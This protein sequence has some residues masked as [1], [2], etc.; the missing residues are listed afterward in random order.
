M[1]TEYWL[2]AS[3]DKATTFDDCGTYIVYGVGNSPGEALQCSVDTGGLLALESETVLYVERCTRELYRFIHKNG[4]HNVK[5]YIE[6]E[7]GF[8]DVKWKL[9]KG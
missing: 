6:L 8:S 1:K 3:L 7:R 5:M 9:F 2:V 4:G